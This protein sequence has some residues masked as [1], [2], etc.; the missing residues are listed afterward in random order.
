MAD[1]IYLMEPGSR[2]T[3]QRAVALVTD[4]ARAHDMNIFIDRGRGPRHYQWLH[5]PRS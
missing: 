1:F 5:Y 4:V 2:R 3:K